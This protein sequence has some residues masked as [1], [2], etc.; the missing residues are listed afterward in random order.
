MDKGILFSLT[1]AYHNLVIIIVV[2]RI[3]IIVVVIIITT[4]VVIMIISPESRD[5]AYV[6]SMLQASFASDKGEVGWGGGVERRWLWWQNQP[7]RSQV[8]V[9]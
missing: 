3:V 4:T 9:S 7:L 1:F 8:S 2:M 6:L 5:A